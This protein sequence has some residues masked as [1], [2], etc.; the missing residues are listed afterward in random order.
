RLISEDDGYVPSRTIQG[1][2]KLINSDKVFA[3]TSVSGTAQAQAAMP[4]I[5]QSGIPA[6]A[7]ITTYEGL[8]DP[9]IKNVF[10]VGY[11]MA[12]AVA[13]LVSQMA[14]RYPGRKWALI[15]QDDEYG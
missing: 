9:V 7:P 15:S 2:R 5:Q 6:M 4:L 12:D 3:L 1:V 11:D 8:Y 14:D 13:E 10:A